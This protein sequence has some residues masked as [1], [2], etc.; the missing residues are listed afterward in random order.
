[1]KFG[2]GAPAWA[3]LDEGRPHTKGAVWS[4]AYYVSEAVQTDFDHF[5][6][7]SPASDGVGL[8]D[9]Y[10]HVWRRVA[11]RFKEEPTV[12]GFDL[13]NE[14]FPGRDAGKVQLALIAR[15][16]EQLAKRPGG[17]TLTVEQLAGMEGTPDGRKQIT[18]WL[19]DLDLY[20]RMLKAGIP[21][22]QQ[23]DQAHLQPFYARVRSAIREVDSRHIIFFEPAMSANLGIPSALLPLSTRRANATGSKPTHRKGTTSWWIH[24]RSS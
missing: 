4:D 20:K 1:V 10:A 19:A 18:Q 16:A 5:W 24:L 23:F 21:I 15:L 7:N 6:A 12:L 14:P 3:A 8:Q 17:S 2:D 22:M 13:M 9:H 11:E